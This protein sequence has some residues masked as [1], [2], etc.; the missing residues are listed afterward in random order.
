MIQFINSSKM[1]NSQ[2]KNKLGCFVKMLPPNY[3]LSSLEEALSYGANCFMFYTGSPQS[4]YRVPIGSLKINEFKAALKKTKINI[5]D[6]AIH[7]PYIMNL[8]NDDPTKRNWA[9]ILLSN[10]IER[11]S[12]IGINFVVLHPGN[13]K[14]KLLGCKYIADAIN[15]I[16]ESNI[17]V[18]ICLETMAGK[19]NEI[20][21]NFIEIKT[22]ID[23]IINK[24]K[25]G[26]CLDT[27][28][29]NDSG[30]DVSN[31][32]KI[33]AIFD[34]IV[35]LRYIKLVHINDSSNFIGSKKDRHA[36]IGKGTIGLENLKKWVHNSAL[37]SIPKFLETPYINNKSIYE[38]EIKLLLSR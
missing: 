31:P 33:L 12:I 15:K 7:C 6:L 23:L 28:H 27:C 37:I 9:K 13:N 30:I 2:Q 4:S 26:V 36:N 17:N 5:N 25:I 1:T 38:E 8:A 18:T 34:K 35:G 19:G 22:I 20:G 11:A 16:N 21:A 10:E 3:L 24:N 14:N 29:L 32:N